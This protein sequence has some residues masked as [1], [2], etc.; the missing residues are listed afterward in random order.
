VLRGGAWYE[1][2]RNC[3]SAYRNSEFIEG[4]A[5]GIGFRVVVLY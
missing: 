3:R 4:R 5:S 2:P 1:G